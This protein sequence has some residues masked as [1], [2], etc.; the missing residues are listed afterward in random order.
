PLGQVQHHLG[1]RPGPARLD[2]AE[3]PRRDA[4]LQRELHLAHATALAPVTQQ[5][6]HPTG[7]VLGDRHH[8]EPTC[9]GMSRVRAATPASATASATTLIWNA[10]ANPCDRAP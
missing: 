8:H 3:M 9:A 5:R 1:A 4:R 2:E 10:P 6:T 7:V